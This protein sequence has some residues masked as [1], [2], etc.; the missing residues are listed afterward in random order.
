[1][2]H[3]T[4]PPH[5]LVALDWPDVLAWFV[6]HNGEHMDV[7]M[8]TRPGGVLLDGETVLTVHDCRPGR[9]PATLRLDLAAG[10]RVYLSER[11]AHGCIEERATGELTVLVG[12]VALMLRPL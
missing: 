4:P 8:E 1:M 7:T 6:G 10:L 9:T 11:T 5:P 2:E 3:V 12:D